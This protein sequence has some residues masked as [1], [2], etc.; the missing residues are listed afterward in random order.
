M[1]WISVHACVDGPKLRDLRKKLGCSKFEATGILVYLWLWGLENAEKNGHILSADKED[2]EECFGSSGCKIPTNRIVDA[3]IETKWIDDTPDGL[4]LHDWEEWQEQWYKA[5]ARRESDNARKKESRRKQAVAS[6]ASADDGTSE[7]E[8][9]EIPQDSPQNP[10][11]TDKKGEENAPVTPPTKKKESKYTTDFDE[12]WSVYPRN[13]DKGGAFKKYQTRVKEGFSPAQL[14]TA[15]KNYALQCRRLG[16]EQRYIKH[17]ATFLSDTRPFLDFL[18]KEVEVVAPSEEG[19]S[20]NP[21]QDW[22]EN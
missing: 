18:P 17:A 19:Q 8:S 12:F 11:E 16:T 9:V 15:A 1:A 4:Y 2:V 10:I 6:S 22:S 5:K 7:E 13:A 14:L 3:L 20:G 21:F